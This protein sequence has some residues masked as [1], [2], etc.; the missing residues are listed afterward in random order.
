M[1]TGE[2]AEVSLSVRLTALFD[3]VR[4]PRTGRN[5]T[6]YD[7]VV[8][9]RQ[10]LASLPVDVQRNRAISHP[11]LCHLLQGE[12]DN[13][14]LGALQSLAEFFGVLPSY[15]TDPALTELEVQF[16]AMIAAGPAPPA[17]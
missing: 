14:K 17:T 6:P 12:R 4:D 9:V 10:Q 13:P 15:F 7:V 2:T 16:Q 5:Y 11:Y 1:S 8:G 3:Q